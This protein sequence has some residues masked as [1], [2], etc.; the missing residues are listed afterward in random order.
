MYVCMY[1]TFS[2]YWKYMV[3]HGDIIISFLCW[4]YPR[5]LWG[6]PWQSPTEPSLEASLD[7]VFF[8]LRA[9]LAVTSWPRRERK[10]H[11]KRFK[12]FWKQGESPSSPK[13]AMFNMSPARFNMLNGKTNYPGSLAWESLTWRREGNQKRVWFFMTA[14]RSRNYSISSGPHPDTLVKKEQVFECFLV[15]ALW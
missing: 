11:L 14:T 8:F 6:R 12:I 1:I 9:G 15:P 5:E 2:L 13:L 7:L 4:I 3:F 10:K